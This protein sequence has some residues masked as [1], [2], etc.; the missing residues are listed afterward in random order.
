MLEIG[1]GIGDVGL[2]LLEAGASRAVNV[3]LSRGYED[4][5]RQLIERSGSAAR[6]EREIGD[7]VR[8][9]GRIASADAVI[10]DRVVCC[11][12]DS[13]ALVSA[14]AGHARE[15]LVLTFPVDRW[16]TRLG[17]GLINVWPRLRGSRF[18]FY[19]HPARTVV[20][21]AEAAGL[22]LRE[23]RVGILWQLLVFTR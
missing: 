15:I 14:A 10:L 4:A 19:V 7:F 16:W 13:A 17:R 1:G 5:A 22:R 12:P 9:A 6:V 2:A 21:A 8:E 23:R 20:G 18:R 3:E 11:Y